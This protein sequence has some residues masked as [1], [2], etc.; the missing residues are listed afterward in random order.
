MTIFHRPGQDISDLGFRN[1]VLIDVRLPGG[2]I[3]EV[4]DN[5]WPIL[6]SS[7]PPP[8]ADGEIGPV[9]TSPNRQR[10]RKRATRQIIAGSFGRHLP[11]ESRAASQ[12]EH[13]AF[14]QSSYA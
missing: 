9:Q 6:R 8:I 10:L 13:N 11:G 12:I 1:L 5:H 3:D 7:A 4:A 2:R 14:F